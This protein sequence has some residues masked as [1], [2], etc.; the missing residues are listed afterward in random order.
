MNKEELISKIFAGEGEDFVI[1]TINDVDFK[2]PILKTKDLKFFIR[3]GAS[4]DKLSEELLKK[5]LKLNELPVE[6][7][8]SVRLG[9]ASQLLE[10]VMEVNGLAKK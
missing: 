6:K 3:G 4:E 9:F 1:R 7:V 2:I 8:D 5:V 10:A